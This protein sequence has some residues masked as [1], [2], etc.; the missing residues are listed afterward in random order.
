[1]RRLALLFLVLSIQTSFAANVGLTAQHALTT[2]DDLYAVQGTKHSTGKSNLLTLKVRDGAASLTA[3]VIDVSTPVLLLAEKMEPTAAISASA[4]GTV[5][6]PALELSVEGD[7]VD[8]RVLGTPDIGSGAFSASVECCCAP[9]DG[10]CSSTGNG[11]SECGTAT[12]EGWFAVPDAAA[13]CI[14][15][16]A[17]SMGIRARRDSA[18]S[19]IVGFPF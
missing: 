14:A 5:T 10:D 12:S 17:G 4:S 6:Y 9:N 18:V 1:M 2:S 7:L 8:M 19:D 11:W 13:Y 15:E 16:L 3:P